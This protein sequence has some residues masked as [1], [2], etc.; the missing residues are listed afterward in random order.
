MSMDN[1]HLKSA[2]LD[3]AYE[4]LTHGE[5]DGFDK[6]IIVIHEE[7]VATREQIVEHCGGNGGTSGTEKTTIWTALT[8]GVA[9]V[10][11]AAG[12]KLGVV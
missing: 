8:T 12:H 7:S 2:L 10:V 3:D 1:G 6:L 4:K 5:A 9:A 11:V